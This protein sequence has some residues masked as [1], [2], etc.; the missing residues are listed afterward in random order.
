[1]FENNPCFR[2]VFGYIPISVSNDFL[3]VL[4]GLF[5]VGG[6]FGTFL[7]IMK[8][9]PELGGMEVSDAKRPKRSWTPSSPASPSR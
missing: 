7:G 6:I 5:I 1:M 8:A 9:L 3:A 2:K 4:P